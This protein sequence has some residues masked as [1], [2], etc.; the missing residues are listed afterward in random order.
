MRLNVRIFK[1]ARY[2][3]S[4]WIA[5]SRGR[6][7]FFVVTV[8]IGVA[9]MVAAV[10]AY[11]R[12]ATNGVTLIR[13]APALINQNPRQ[14]QS[15]FHRRLAF[16]PEVDRFRRRLGERFIKS[17]RER[18]TL[19][20]TLTVGAQQFQ[21]RIIRTQNEDGEQVDVTLNGGG[22]LSWNG[23][24]GAKSAGRDAAGAERSLIERIALDSPDQFV[25]AQM[26]GASY[27]TV[28]RMVEPAGAG[29][30]YSGPVWDLIRIVEPQSGASAKPQNEW[31]VYYVNCST[32]LI[33]KI[34]YQDQGQTVTVDLSGWANRGGEIEPSLIRWRRDGKL[35]MELSLNNI[36]HGAKQ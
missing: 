15:D 5:A 9:L 1:G 8:M 14:A 36:G 2:K 33:D 17:G 12:A 32:G 13:P 23:K 16:Q 22:P 30:D 26:R 19:A 7:V 28:A 27:Y 35:E 3:G 4:K 20:G 29:D 6:S 11:N 18:A 34:V 25:L 10:R 21:A 24:G 31:R